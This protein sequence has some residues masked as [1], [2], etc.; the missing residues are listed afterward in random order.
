VQNV[1]KKYRTRVKGTIWFVGENCAAWGLANPVV[2]GRDGKTYSYSYGS[3][4]RGD[5]HADTR[6]ELKHGLNQFFKKGT[7]CELI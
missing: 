7:S 3:M 2:L 4:P 1:V 6:W 5:F